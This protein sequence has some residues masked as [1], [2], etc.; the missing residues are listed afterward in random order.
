MNNRYKFSTHSWPAPSTLPAFY[1]C[2]FIHPKDGSTTYTPSRPLLLLSLSHTFPSLL[3]SDSL[4]YTLFR[5]SFSKA[6]VTT[7]KLPTRLRIIQSE[8]L[9]DRFPQSIMGRHYF[10]HINI[11]NKVAG[12]FGV[13]FLYGAC[14]TYSKLEHCRTVE[15]SWTDTQRDVGEHPA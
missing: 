8:S 14:S 7:H 12:A 9:T 6:L 1:L 5:S 10:H 3:T 4:F 15:L 2:L 11:S 13:S